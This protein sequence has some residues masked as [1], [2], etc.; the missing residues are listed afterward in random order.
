MNVKQFLD[1]PR[2]TNYWCT[3][4]TLNVYL[5]KSMRN[6]DGQHVLTIDIA[7]L[8]NTSSRGQGDFW[9]LLVFLM[10]HAPKEFG[11]FYIENVQNKT[12]A[13]SLKLEG[14][15]VIENS[16]SDVPWPDSFYHLRIVREVLTNETTV[17]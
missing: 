9:A 16:G 13:R 11:A 10:V 12:L 6:L 4:R 2:V 7:N 15:N 5:R 17:L 3:H 8:T 1:S 14:W